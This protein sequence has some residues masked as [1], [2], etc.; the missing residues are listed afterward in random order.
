[1][2]AVGKPERG[3]DENHRADFLGMPQSVFDHRAGA[4][5]VAD[6]GRARQAERGDERVQTLRLIDARVGPA[7]AALGETEGRQVDRDRLILYPAFPIA[8]AI[9]SQKPLQAAVPGTNTIGG[10]DSGPLDCTKM[11]PAAVATSRP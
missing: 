9:G 2:F 6:D 4:E 1:M 3:V 8:R 11:A 7:G 5:R 10:P